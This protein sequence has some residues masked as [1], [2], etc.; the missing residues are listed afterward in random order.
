M[1]WCRVW[2]RSLSSTQIPT[3]LFLCILYVDTLAL[4]NLNA[5]HISKVSALNES[6]RHGTI[7]QAPGHRLPQGGDIVSIK[8][9][10]K[11][12]TVTKYQRQTT[13]KEKRATFHPV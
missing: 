6:Q 7:S 1:G 3:C 10:Q 4:Y 5:W 13:Y 11:P 12:V 2:M 9:C 8:I